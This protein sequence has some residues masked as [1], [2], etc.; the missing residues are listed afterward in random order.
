[1]FVLYGFVLSFNSMSSK[2]ILLTYIVLNLCC[3]FLIPVTEKFLPSFHTSETE[4]YLR[5]RGKRELRAGEKTLSRKN[6]HDKS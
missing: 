2:I 3:K 5:K 4:N 1:M 6:T